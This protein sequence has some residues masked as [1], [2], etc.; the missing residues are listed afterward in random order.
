MTN[1]AAFEFANSPY[2]Y[3]SGSK[4]LFSCDVGGRIGAVNYQPPGGGGA[5][6]LVSAISYQPFGPAAS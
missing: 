5:S 2:T 4:V 3:P 6:V 1:S